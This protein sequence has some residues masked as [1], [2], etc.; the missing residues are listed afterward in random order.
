MTQQ[1]AASDTLRDLAG[2]AR[3]A[4]VPVVHGADTIDSF[5]AALRA[6]L[7]G[8]ELTTIVAKVAAVGPTSFHMD[9]PLL[10][11]RFQFRRHIEQLARRAAVAP[12]AAAAIDT[13]TEIMAAETAEL[14]PAS[15]AAAASPVDRP[16]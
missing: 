14:S 10:E 9:L 1:P 4:G 7:A 5:Q 2:I 11:N 8:R 15:R 13:E 3:A 12:A 6:A 16:Q